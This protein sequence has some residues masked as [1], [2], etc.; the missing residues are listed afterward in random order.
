LQR[1]MDSASGSTGWECARSSTNGHQ[2]KVCNAFPAKLG[3]LLP[4]S[5]NSA[6]VQFE[7]SKS[8]RAQIILCGAVETEVLPHNLRGMRCRNPKRQ[9]RRQRNDLFRC[10]RCKKI[11]HLKIR[12]L[13]H[14]KTKHHQTRQLPSRQ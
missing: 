11:Q 5:Q 2:A 14:P 12:Q 6:L 4:G 3:A 7:R 13:L 1:N 8:F 10:D 9:T